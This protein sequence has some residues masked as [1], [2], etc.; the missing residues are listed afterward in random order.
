VSIRTD[1]HA[2]MGWPFS[3]CSGVDA[4]KKETKHWDH[5]MFNLKCKL[6]PK[7]YMLSFVYDRVPVMGDD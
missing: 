2:G 4:E 1:A 5:T 7:K 3:C 6:E